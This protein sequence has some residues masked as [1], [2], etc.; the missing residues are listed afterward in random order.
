MAYDTVALRAG[1]SGHQDVADAADRAV[2]AYAQLHIVQTV[3]GR[4]AA[5]AGLSAAVEA[6]RQSQGRA[7]AAEVAAR[8]DLAKRVNAAAN[9]GDGLTVA[10][11]AIASR[12]HAPGLIAAD[13][14]S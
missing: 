14:L 12:V 7:A 6:A 13:M 9:S 10:S 3:F 8:I 11:S 5:A 2:G 1:A 4:V